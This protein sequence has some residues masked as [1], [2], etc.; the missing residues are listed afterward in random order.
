MFYLYRNAFSYA[1]L[2]Y[3]SAMAVILFIVGIILA[4][5][6]FG[7]SRRYVHYSVES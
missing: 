3:A 1:Q 5:L 2:G 7:L 4:L 6:I